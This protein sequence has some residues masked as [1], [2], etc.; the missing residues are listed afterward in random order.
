MTVLEYDISI[1]L[2]I[3]RKPI[4]YSGFYNDKRLEF[5]VRSGFEIYVRYN[6]IIFL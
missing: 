6:Y 4:L 2:L 5:S 3:F 1:T